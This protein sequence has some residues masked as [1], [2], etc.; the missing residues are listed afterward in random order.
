MTN[1]FEVVLG[2]L[3]KYGF[4]YP[5]CALEEHKRL[6]FGSLGISSRMLCPTPS[7]YGRHLQ[8]PTPFP[9]IAPEICYPSLRRTFY[10]LSSPYRS[11]RNAGSSAI[12]GPPVGTYL[13]WVYPRHKWF[14]R[15]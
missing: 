5:L 12:A 15:L 13:G 2:R 4:L 10:Y 6:G 9:H 8:Y 3:D 11:L 14:P 1:Q 7:D